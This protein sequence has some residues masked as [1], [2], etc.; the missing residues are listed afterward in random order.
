ML[1]SFILSFPRELSHSRKVPWVEYWDFLDGCIYVDP[2]TLHCNVLTSFIL[3]FPRELARSMKV[4]WAEYWDFLDAYVDLST[5]EGL[6]QLEE[7]LLGRQDIQGQQD[8]QRKM[9]VEGGYTKN[10]YHYVKKCFFQFV[11]CLLYLKLA[12]FVCYNGT[13]IKENKNSTKPS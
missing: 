10:T 5:T 3:S 13:G 9:S 12:F 6:I 4:P 2:S 7:Y 8:I 1:T 11:I